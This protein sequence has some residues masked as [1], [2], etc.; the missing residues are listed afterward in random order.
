MAFQTAEPSILANEKGIQ[1]DQQ[2]I[3]LFFT[4]NLSEIWKIKPQ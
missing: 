3:D 2:D 4:K 1:F